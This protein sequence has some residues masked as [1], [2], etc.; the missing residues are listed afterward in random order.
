MFPI[1]DPGAGPP[2]GP[3]R[4]ASTRR[5]ARSPRRSPWRCPRSGRRPRPSASR[6]MAALPPLPQRAGRGDLDYEAG[7]GCPGPR[8]RVT[9]GP[10]DRAARRLGRRRLHVG[11]YETLDQTYGALMG[12]IAEQGRSVAGPMWEVYWSD[13]GAE[14]DPTRWRTEVIVPVA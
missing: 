10:C 14:P 9:A 5:S 8:P 6:R 7:V 3:W 12:W 11:P 2:A 13:P 4:S 1:R